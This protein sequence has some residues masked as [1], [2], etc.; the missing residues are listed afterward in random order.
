MPD[1]PP[2][3]LESPKPL[4]RDPADYLGDLVQELNAILWEADAA[5]WRFLFV[6][7][8]AEAILGYPV[9]RW[10]H[11][12]DFW[13]NHIYPADRERAVSLWRE[14]TAR[15]EDHEF[16]YRMMSADG[17]VVWLQ[18]MVRV[19]KDETG[20]PRLLYGLMLDITAR[21]RAEEQSQRRLESLNLLIAAAEKIVEDRDVA[22][23]VQGV[24]NTI[25]TSFGFRLAWIGR[26][27]P[28]GRV[29]P[30][31]WAGDVGAYLKTVEVRWDDSPLGRGPAGTAI[32]S[33][34]PVISDIE[35]DPRF[36]PWRERALAHGYR[37]I[38]ALPILTDE[39][40]FGVLILYSGE[41]GFFTPE[42]VKLLQ[43][44]THI[45]TAALKNALL[46]EET[47]R[48][49]REQEALNAITLAIGQSVHLQDVFNIAL[50]KVL[51]VTRRERGYIRLRDPVSGEVRLAAGRGISPEHAHALVHLRT[52]GGKS[53]R[54]FATGEVLVFNSAAMKER[55]V[56][57][58]REGVYAAVW[59]PLKS[60]GKVVGILNVATRKPVDFTPR[61][62]SFLEA[63]GNVMGV[64]LDN[65]RL[66]SDTQ[67]NLERLR[68]LREIDEAISSTLDLRV[69]LDLLLEKIGAL[70][71][72]SATTVRLHNPETGLL[73]PVACHNLD[74]EEW[75]AERWKGGRGIPNVVFACQKPWIVRNVQSDPNVKD[76]EFFKRHG[77]VSYLGLPLSA[78]GERLGVLSIYTKHDHGFTDEEVRFL[79][80]LAGQ[81]AMAIHNSQLYERLKKQTLELEEARRKQADFTAIIAHDL[82]SPLMSVIGAAGMM[83]DGLFGPVS[84]E[85]RKWLAKIGE[86]CRALV[87]L[88][89]DFLDL[90]KLESGR[91]DLSKQEVR[92]DELI[93][94]A[95]ETYQVVAKEK[96]IALRAEI[97]PGLPPIVAD[98]R[99][100]EQV[101]SNL[102]TNAI[103]F[104]APRGVVEI[105]AAWRD[106][107]GAQVAVT[108]TGAGIA[109]DERSH[110][111]EKYRQTTSG[112]TSAYKGTGLG[113]VICKMIVEAHGGKIWV[114]SE[115]GRGSTFF[116]TLPPGG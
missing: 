52:P 113:L 9:E 87:E 57:G 50:D 116:F 47:E 21:K 59:V 69:V 43:S 98:R 18:D 22:N 36:A 106:G 29:R 104:T 75:K 74:A 55:T 89:S 90:S 34:Q 27:E 5:T 7:K 66:F 45:A 60:Q 17:R 67:Q 103:K 42:R 111:F 31:Y 14:F 76:Q 71:P 86:N 15:G 62:V 85:Q 2:P 96:E 78:K 4:P 46:L 1:K 114:E 108:D 19:V 10:L 37:E 49:A 94:D 30:L 112:K 53:D 51:E 81:A 84:E 28:D 88:V 63:I 70:L 13:V 80:T 6:S 65:A 25:V 11:E 48:R 82:R 73:E 54:V 91:L 105:R 39:K 102:L 68:I 77:L 35:T 100:L 38:A 20:T 72:Y 101:L 8:K 24:L 32:R 58:R 107:E 3:D 93:H 12:P 97:A 56:K 26:T 33:R 40:P 83:Q 61:E 44:Y 64:A 110:I 41:T 115:E 79:S 92:L 109:A 95:I 16:E 23:L 99:R